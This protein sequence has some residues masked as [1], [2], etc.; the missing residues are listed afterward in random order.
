MGS[1]WALLNTFNIMNTITQKL[2]LVYP[3]VENDSFKDYIV[4]SSDSL[5]II[6]KE[7]ELVEWIVE[8][9]DKDG[10]YMSAETEDDFLDAIIFFK[11]ILLSGDNPTLYI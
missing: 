11:S 4:I 9:E 8:G 7:L 10:T 2:S 1:L 5:L 6:N 3:Y